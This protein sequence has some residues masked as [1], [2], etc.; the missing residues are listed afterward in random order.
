MSI[1][2]LTPVFEIIGSNS[3]KLTALRKLFAD[4]PAGLQGIEELETVFKYLSSIKT[5]NVVSVL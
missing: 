3:K 5:K 2:K 4:S 1:D